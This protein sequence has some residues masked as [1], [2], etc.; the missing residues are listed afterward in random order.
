MPIP[1]DF[2]HNF[3]SGG[4]HS[5]PHK[6][7]RRR[8]RTCRIEE[9][10]NREMLSVTLGDFNVLREQ[11][12][13]LNLRDDYESYNF[14]EIEAHELTSNN[15]RSA[16]TEARNSAKDDIIVIRTTETQHTVTLG[17]S[18]LAININAASWGSIA[19]VSLGTDSLTIDAQKWSR[20]FN[21]GSGS[22]VALAGLTITN[23]NS[24]KGGGIIN[25]GVLNVVK[26][27]LTG[28]SA[29]SNGGGIYNNAGS[30][31]TM[32]GSTITGNTSLGGLLTGGGGIYNEGIFATTN[33]VIVANSALFIGGGILNLGSFAITNCLLA[34]NSGS[35]QGGAIDNDTGAMT[36]TN[37]T[38]TGNTAREGGGI[39]T[40]YQAS[41]TINNT[42]VAK[43]SAEDIYNYTN[44]FGL[45]FSSDNLFGNHNLIGS[46]VGLNALI[47]NINGTGNIFG[48]DPMF[49]NPALG[50]YRLADSSPA[51]DKGSNQYV[52]SGL[53]RDLA[54]NARIINGTVD[55]GAYENGNAPPLLPPDAPISF[56]AIDRTTNSITLAWNQVVYVNGVQVVK[57]FQVRYRMADDQSWQTTETFVSTAQSDATVLPNFTIDILGL[58][59]NTEYEFQI[60]AWNDAG[61]SAWVPAAPLCVWTLPEV[62]A[63]KTPLTAPILE[64]VT[65]LSDISIGIIWNTV[66]NASGYRVEYSTDEFFAENVGLVDSTVGFAVITGLAPNTT[67]FVRVMAIGSGEF[68]DSLYSETMSA[69]TQAA[70]VVK[71]QLDTPAA[72]EVI[73]RGVQ[74][75]T[76]CWTGVE[77][78]E[79]YEIQWATDE[80][81]VYAIGM[82]HSNTT[83]FEIANLLPG[84]TYFIR[85]AAITTAEGFEN[86]EW[87]LPVSA[88][89]ITPLTPPNNIFVS[90]KTTDSIT[91]DWDK[92]NNASGYEVRYRKPG[93]EEWTSVSVSGTSTTI[94]GLDD[95]T[96]YEFQVQAVNG[97][98]ESVWSASVFDTTIAST[99]EIDVTDKTSSSISLQ[100]N[101][102]CEATHVN[103]I[104]TAD[105]FGWQVATLITSANSGYV[106]PVRNSDNR[107]TSVGTQWDDINVNWDSVVWADV[108]PGARITWTTPEVDNWYKKWVSAP[109]GDSQN[110]MRNGFYAFQYSLFATENETAVNG[111]LNFALGGDDYIAAIYANGKKIYESNGGVVVGAQIS[112]MPWTTLENLMFDVDLINGRLDLMFIVHNSNLGGSSSA[113]AMGLFV[114]GTLSTNVLMNPYEVRYRTV[115]ESGNGVWSSTHITYTDNTSVVDGLMPNTTYEFQVRSKG[116]GDPNVGW[117]ESV[118]ATTDAV[119]WADFRS[120]DKTDASVSFG[121]EAV[122]GAV[123]Y[124]I[125]YRPVSDAGSGQWASKNVSTTGTAVTVT[126]LNPDTT[127][128]FQLRSKGSGSANSAW[129]SSITVT[130]YAEYSIVTANNLISPMLAPVSGVKL[131]RTISKPTQ[132][133]LTFTWFPPSTFSADAIMFD[134]L[135]PKPKSWARNAKAPCIAT[136]TVTY[137]EFANILN[138]SYTSRTFGDYVVTFTQKIDK[139]KVGIDVKI[140]GL[141]AATK[142]TVR[143]QSA[144]GTGNYSRVTKISAS[145]AKYAAP[146]KSG[147]PV[148][149]SDTVTFYWKQSRI[150]PAGMDADAVRS[151]TVGIFI[152][153]EF[154]AFGSGDGEH[155]RVVSG[156]SITITV[157]GTKAVVAGLAQQRYTFGVQEFVSV[158]DDVAQSAIAKISVGVRR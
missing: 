105:L 47:N 10:E 115:T 139:W 20:G 12:N 113:N 52:P 1:T 86:S 28:N 34:E 146:Q 152:G 93:D 136:V 5:K 108:V 141:K 39:Y 35:L 66:D 123:S 2:F 109:E 72:P 133:S 87:S 81:F 75:L 114:D 135:A 36:I 90:N 129:S 107:Y 9:L 156:N 64:S 92:V 97:N 128:E 100:W 43:N 112:E 14:I 117:S 19:I 154:I 94:L 76:V 77:N 88:A 151:Y 27:T 18:E 144:D 124:E 155:T 121:W 145:T 22:V 137:E 70:A 102:I 23:G 32:Y 125:R 48:V 95:N 59:P 80:N 79:E 131:D 158:G 16:I 15:F 91:L 31:V 119:I 13:D 150:A 30:K 4:S 74:T 25:S 62:P 11:Y 126:G 51:I 46:G 96:E 149:G 103:T 73:E 53:T 78:A 153:N 58:N 106:N 83:S 8:G 56:R 17:G 49:A 157:T 7:K 111:L 33:S 147:S 50:D 130:T 120:T 148:F 118:F 89:T 138:G 40:T 42:I 85:V 6:A 24:T 127:Y 65:A 71:I 101:N 68:S 84:E 132:T 60:S 69:T 140:S 54:G 41:L 29:E 26:S 142:Y 67:Y 61:N 44:V 99:L 82:G 38:I 21:I 37:S 116:N 45:I 143:M 57:G 122:P 104:S 3:F 55:I 110:R 134:V 98:D 63:D